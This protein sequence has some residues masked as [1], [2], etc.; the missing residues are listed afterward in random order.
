MIKDQKY[1][2]NLK[3]KHVVLLF[4]TTGSGKSTFANALLNGSG[5]LKRNEKG[6]IELKTSEG[7]V[8]EF[9]IGHEVISETKAPNYHPLTDEG[10]VNLVD[11]P[12]I[13]DSNFRYEFA[14]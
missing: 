7:K 8:T 1:L 9:K 2:Q 3:D 6:L 12:G 11:G 5:K 10:D 4:G 14:N 13:N